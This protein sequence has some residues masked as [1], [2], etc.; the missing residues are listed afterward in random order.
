MVSTGQAQGTT[1]RT[2]VLLF[3]GLVVLLHTDQRHG[4]L[5][6]Q[7]LDTMPRFRGCL[8]EHDVQFCR[9][10]IGFL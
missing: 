7:A 4:N 6:E 9:F 2:C 3:C 10:G 1:A 5:L 8:H